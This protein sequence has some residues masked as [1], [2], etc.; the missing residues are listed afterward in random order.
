ML[1]KIRCGFSEPASLV[2]SLLGLGACLLSLRQWKIWLQTQSTTTWWAA[3]WSRTTRLK[4]LLILVRPIASKLELVSDP[5]LGQ[6]RRKSYD[7]S[8][9][10]ILDDIGYIQ[11]NIKWYIDARHISAWL[12]WDAEAIALAGQRRCISPV[13][14]WR[15]LVRWFYWSHRILWPNFDPK[16]R[17]KSGRDPHFALQTFQKDLSGA[18]LQPKAGL[19][20]G[21]QPTKKQEY[22]M[23]VLFLGA[24]I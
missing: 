5:F 19:L 24:T 15:P 6:L 2:S 22:H 11:T 9:W 21:S 20:G 1:I 3:P 13:L 23:T 12:Y 17:Q 10:T 4:F 18:I 8:C 16:N 14:Q 7:R